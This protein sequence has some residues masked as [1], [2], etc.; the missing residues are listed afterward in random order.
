VR[1]SSATGQAVGEKGNRKSEFE[2]KQKG[3][4]GRANLCGWKMPLSRDG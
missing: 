4:G 3:K 2:T 1:A